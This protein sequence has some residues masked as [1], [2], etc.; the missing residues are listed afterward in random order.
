[1]SSLKLMLIINAIFFVSVFLAKSVFIAFIITSIAIFVIFLLLYR[2]KIVDIHYN[3][4]EKYAITNVHYNTMMLCLIIFILLEQPIG[5]HASLF[6]SFFIF[7]HLNKLPNRIAFFLA[8]ILLVITAFFIAARNNVAA[9]LSATI[10]YYFLIV[11]VVWF[12]VE[13]VI[14]KLE[15]LNNY[16]QPHD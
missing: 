4:K 3:F 6:T 13:F 8:L 16:I 1:M 12:F 14:Q 11:G 2:I 10:T 7:A 9:E 15:G 5:T